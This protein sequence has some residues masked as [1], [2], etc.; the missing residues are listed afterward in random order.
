MLMPALHLEK[1]PEAVLYSAS[2]PMT[3]LALPTVAERL[4]AG[5]WHRETDTAAAPY[6]WRVRNASCETKTSELVYS[7]N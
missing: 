2:I 3:M 7:L 6:S 5:D 1:V 4:I